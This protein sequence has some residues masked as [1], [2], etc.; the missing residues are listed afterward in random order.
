MHGGSALSCIA[1]AQAKK[2]EAVR[3]ENF[4]SARM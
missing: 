3:D 2:D 4:S 1:V